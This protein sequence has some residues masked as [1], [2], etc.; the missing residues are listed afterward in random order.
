MT[1]RHTGG[2]GAARKPAGEGKPRPDGPGAT[3]A[4]RPGDAQTV[5]VVAFGGGHG[6]SATLRALRGV[7]TQMPLEITAVVTVADDGGSSGRLR[8]TRDILP[9]GDL[10]QALAAL[11]DEAAMAELFQHRFTGEDEIAGH[12]VGNLVLVALLEQAGDPVAALDRA[13]AMLRCH[14]RVLPMSRD[15][16]HIEAD[17]SDGDEVVTVRGQH[18][19]AV[20]AKTI[21]RVR[22]T[23][24]PPEAC[25]EA[26]KAVRE[27]DWLLFGPGSWFTSVIPHLLVPGLAAAI[28]ASAARRLVTL[29][30][31]ADSETAGLTLPEHL[32]A[33]RRYLP[34]LQVD[35]V[36]AD[37]KAVGDP[38]P[39][40]RAAESLGA[41]LVLAP[42]AVS[43]GAPRHDPQALAM[44]LEPLLRVDT[45]AA[46]RSSGNGRV[47]AKNQTSA[48]N[49]NGT[50]SARG[51]DMTLNTKTAR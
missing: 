2:N 34:G 7:Q 40:H 23:P 51:K 48:R 38:E 5:R 39:V 35:V 4:V 6:L 16:L 37:G 13:A 42:V 33:L 43:D 45:R 14:G 10:R 3:A 21:D 46:G 41:R 19:V 32:A 9:P 22:L 49:A 25:A 15:P 36:L 28:T 30:L 44:A 8:Q 12:P 20:T 24:D 18:E 1:S 47:G 17:L 27:A 11:A 26:V 29:N 31:A 50:G